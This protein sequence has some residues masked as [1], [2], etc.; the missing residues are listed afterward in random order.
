MRSE[1]AYYG[2]IDALASGFRALRD[3]ACA[4]WLGPVVPGATMAFGARVPGTSYVLDP[5]QAAFN[6][7]VMVGWP[8]GAGDGQEPW[9]GSHA[10]PADTLAG[11]LVVADFLARQALAEARPPLTLQDVLGRLGQARAIQQRL[12]TT[13]AGT[14]AAGDHAK[15]VRVATAAVVTAM[16][17]GTHDQVA[18]AATCAWVEGDA[19]AADVPAEVASARQGWVLADAASRGVRL[20]WLALAAEADAVVAW[21]PEIRPVLEVIRGH[22]AAEPPLAAAVAARIRE[23]FEASVARHFPLAQ[24]AR[25][26]TL[27]GAP[28][29]LAAMPVNECVSALV[30]N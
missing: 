6:L 3:P 2:L 1:A 21:P 11:V 7:G 10:R 26:Q 27:Y 4:R 17:G 24:A 18:L 19:P 14:G 29:A 16:I 5:V 25:I 22:Q 9:S 20:A 30:R 23:R 28:D 12:A 15:P 13:T 8:A